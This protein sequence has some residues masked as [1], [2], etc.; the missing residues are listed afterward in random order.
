MISRTLH[1]AVSVDVDRFTDRKL[2]YEYGPCFGLG[3]TAAEIRERCAVARAQGLEVFPPCD[4]VDARGNCRG[5]IL[6]ESRFIEVIVQHGGSFHPWIARLSED[7]QVFIGHGE[8]IHAALGELARLTKTL[9][10]W[11]VRADHGIEVS[12]RFDRD[13]IS[14]DGETIGEAIDHACMRLDRLAR[15]TKFVTVT[16]STALGPTTLGLGALGLG[17]TPLSV[18]LLESGA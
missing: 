3:A 1:V 17:Y 5:H 4:D 2:E 8:T 18:A 7:R 13:S 6:C 10:P 14:G 16:K 12:I 11:W 15:Q 9:R